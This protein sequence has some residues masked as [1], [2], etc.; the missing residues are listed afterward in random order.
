MLCRIMYEEVSVA[1]KNTATVFP[2]WGWNERTVDLLLRILLP[3]VQTKRWF[4]LATPPYTGFLNTFNSQ[5]I[6]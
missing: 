4:H 1:N 5:A 2:K 6:R 3:Q